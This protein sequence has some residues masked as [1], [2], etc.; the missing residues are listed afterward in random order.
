M[1]LRCAFSTFCLLAALLVTSARRDVLTAQIA[2]PPPY[3]TSLSW[4]QRVLR[5]EIYSSARPILGLTHLVGQPVRALGS[6]AGDTALCQELYNRLTAGQ[7][8]AL[9]DTSP[10]YR[11]A[12]FQVGDRY[13]LYWGPRPPYYMRASALT[14]FDLQLNQL[15]TG[16]W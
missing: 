9:A 15:G 12:F 6:S 10:I 1:L 2:C 16:I 3:S 14:G 5:D 11:V 4:V 13:L 8:A 7:G